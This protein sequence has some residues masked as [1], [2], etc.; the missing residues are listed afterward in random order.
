[1]TI[2]LKVAMSTS[3]PAPVCHGRKR[4]DR[5]H[6]AGAVAIRA[7]GFSTIGRLISAESTPNRI[8]G[9]HPPWYERGRS[10]AMPPSQTPRKPP[11][12]WLKKA[13]PAKV[14]SHLVPN[15]SAM[16]PL[17]G[18]TVDSHFRPMIAAKLRKET[19]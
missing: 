15:I 5:G 12:W 17:V 13:K 10:K 6:Q 3:L 11:T 7:T 18:A 2:A 9:H 14:A 16:M 4:Y 19:V 8:A 1:M